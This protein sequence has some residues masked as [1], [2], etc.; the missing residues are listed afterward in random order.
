MWER[1]EEFKQLLAK[2]C[3]KASRSAID[4]LARIAIEDHAQVGV[5]CSPLS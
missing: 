3:S 5:R 4:S 2:C 1:E